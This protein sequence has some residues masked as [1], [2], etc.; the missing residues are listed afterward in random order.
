MKK[1]LAFS[2]FLIVLNILGLWAMAEDGWEIDQIMRFHLVYIPDGAN[3]P[4]KD[5]R[6]VPS[7]GFTPDYLPDID[8]IPLAAIKGLGFY[9]PSRDD[10]QKYKLYLKLFN[11]PSIFKPKN[12]AIPAIQAF[13]FDKMSE[14]VKI[15]EFV[16]KPENIAVK[17]GYIEKADKKFTPEDPAPV[18]AVDATEVFEQGFNDHLLFYSLY[19]TPKSPKTEYASDDERANHSAQGVITFHKEIVELYK[20]AFKSVEGAEPDKYYYFEDSKTNTLIKLPKLPMVFSNWRDLPMPSDP[21][22]HFLSGLLLIYREQ[23]GAGR[24]FEVGSVVRIPRR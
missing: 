8:N 13:S 11:F 15:T 22:H 6:P 20:K 12:C 19:V 17:F 10:E 18:F 23:K 14:G 2:C 16:K 5:A 24:V 7:L 3:M 1:I 4:S 9:L 21:K